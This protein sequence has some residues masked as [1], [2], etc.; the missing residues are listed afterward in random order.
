MNAW[1]VAVEVWLSGD[2][3]RPMTLFRAWSS[4]NLLRNKFTELKSGYSQ[5]M[6]SRDLTVTGSLFLFGTE[7][8]LLSPLTSRDHLRAALFSS[9]C[10][11][12]AMF[13]STLSI[14][15][16]IYCVHMV[17]HF[18]LLL[19]CIQELHSSSLIAKCPQLW[20]TSPQSYSPTDRVISITSHQKWYESHWYLNYFG[21]KTDKRGARP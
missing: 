16:A 13:M 5:I 9:I 4:P 21:I 6:I 20:V 14:H 1:F 19:D 2:L 10:C 3:L 11:S 7:S 15:L 18:V 17:F 12:R 8:W